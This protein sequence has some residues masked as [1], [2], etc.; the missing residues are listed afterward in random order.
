MKK[1]QIDQVHRQY[2]IEITRLNNDNQRL[3]N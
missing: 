2:E 1:L 3:Q